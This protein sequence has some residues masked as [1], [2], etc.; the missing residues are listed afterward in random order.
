MNLQMTARQI[1]GV[2]G[3]RCVELQASRVGA[4]RKPPSGPC[5]LACVAFG[6]TDAQDEL[7]GGIEEVKGEEAK[8]EGAQHRVEEG[9]AFLG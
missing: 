4:A 7:D 5:S 1:S 2:P 8:E 9:T 6:I 3:R